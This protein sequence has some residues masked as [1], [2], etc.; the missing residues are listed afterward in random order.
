VWTLQALHNTQL[1]VLSQQEK[2][3][4]YEVRFVSSTLCD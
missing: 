2:N 1:I 3:K 4:E